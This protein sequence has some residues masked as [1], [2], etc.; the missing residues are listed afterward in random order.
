MLMRMKNK[1][2]KNQADQEVLQANAIEWKKSL[3]ESDK[4]L[5]KAL[6]KLEY[7]QAKTDVFENAYKLGYDDGWDNCKVA[8]RID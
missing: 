2:I 5:L 3:S 8:N 7:D 1:N 6:L 4:K